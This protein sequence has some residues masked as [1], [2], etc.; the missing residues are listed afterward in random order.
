VK[1]LGTPARGFTLIEAIVALT[2]VASL[3]GALFLWINQS[4]NAINRIQAHYDE[5]EL[6]QNVAQWARTLNPMQRPTGKISLG[7]L[8]IEWQSKPVTGLVDQM[9]F[10]AGTGLFQLALYDVSIKA[11]QGS[12][13]A[14]NLL[15]LSST[16]SITG[17][18]KAR[19]LSTPF[20]P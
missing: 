15:T 7:E 5:L 2:L 10:P 1:R 13:A 6:R 14:G 19:D 11:T 8:Q 4:L 12:A 9:G 3:G 18:R 20:G 17:Y 16:R